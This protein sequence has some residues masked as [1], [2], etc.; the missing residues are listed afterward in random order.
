MLF[1]AFQKENCI[2]W[3]QRFAI[4][5]NINCLEILT[6][7]T[8]EMIF[9]E[10]EPVSIKIA[11]NNCQV[12]RINSLNF[13]G[14]SISSSMEIPVNGSQGFGK[15]SKKYFCLKITLWMM[16]FKYEFYQVHFFFLSGKHLK[17]GIPI[18]KYRSLLQLGSI[19][20]RHLHSHRYT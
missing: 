13:L 6:H 9:K 3:T 15:E 11:T 16:S 18:Y 10:R 20:Q 8:N 12:E 1:V 14:N 19:W 17:F 4:T 7:K 5:I 2:P